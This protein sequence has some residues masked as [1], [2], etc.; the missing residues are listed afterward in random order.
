[1]NISPIELIA[2]ASAML[3]VILALPFISLTREDPLRPRPLVF[4]WFTG[5]IG[6]MLPPTVSGEKQQKEELSLAGYY[7]PNSLRNLYAVRAV[8][9]LVPL[10]TGL[11][12]CLLAENRYWWWWPLVG[13]LG[14]SV[15]GF[16]FPRVVIGVRASSRSEELRNGIPVLTDNLAISLSAGRSLVDALR[17]AG[18]TLQRG[19]PE[20]AA[21]A[22]LVVRQAE[23]HS[24]GIALEQFRRRLPIPE[25]V[26]LAFVLSESDRLGSDVTEPLRVIADDFRTNA[27]QRAE[28]RANRTGFYMLFP[29]IFGLGT[30]A[31]IIVLGPLVVEIQSQIQTFN[32]DLNKASKLL[33]QK[34]PSDGTSAPKD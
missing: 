22:R 3:I 28:A 30:A 6:S 13:G 15:L 33:L 32:D 25:L 7:H 10:T 24:L 26:N 20:L 16:A 11:V 23:L 17:D 31:A 34:E 19:E 18:D 27:R 9:T 1:M 12:L 14:L 29:T 2:V 8:L 5:L 21:E 4:G